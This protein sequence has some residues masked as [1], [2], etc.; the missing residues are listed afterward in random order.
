MPSVRL[1]RLPSW[2]LSPWEREVLALLARGL[3]N[4][5]IA[6][7]LGLRNEP[8][9]P[10]A[11]NRPECPHCGEAIATCAVSDLVS[12]ATFHACCPHCGGEWFE[13]RVSG[14]TK[15]FYAEGAR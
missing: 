1:A 12:E 8:Y 2:D 7:R 4:A 13:V 11:P 3:G 6:A 15:R 5:G 9:A 14:V 10:P